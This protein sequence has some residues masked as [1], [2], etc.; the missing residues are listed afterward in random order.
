MT[1]K[2][3]FIILNF[4]RPNNIQRIIDLIRCSR[5]FGRIM[6]SNN[7]PSTNL[8]DYL[9]DDRTGVHVIN[10]PREMPPIIRNQIAWDA[11]GEYFLMIDDDVFLEP[12]QIDFLTKKLAEDPIRLHGV[13]GQNVQIQNGQAVFQSGIHAVNKEVSVLNCVYACTKSH[14]QRF[15][16]IFNQLGYQNLTDLKFGDDIIMSVSGMAPPRCHDLGRLRFCSSFNDPAVAQWK[17]EGFDDARSDLFL[18]LRAFQL[19][20]PASLPR[21]A[22]R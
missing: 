9:S 12:R 16:A 20:T 11:S 19:A 8:H 10:Q 14:I 13:W 18:K 22:D 4:E 5:S 2:A 6:V 15:F 17:K 21:N 1:P 7:K 3:T